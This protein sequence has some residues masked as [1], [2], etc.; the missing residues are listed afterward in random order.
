MK[1]VL[2]VFFSLFILSIKMF[3]GGGP[4][5][6]GYTW[7]DINDVGG[8]TF[9]WFD[10]S[11]I[12]SPLSGLGDDN[13]VGPKP[14]GGNFK[15][16]WGT[17]NKIWAGSN[18]YISFGPANIASPFP[19]IPDASPPNNYIAAMMC[20]LNFTG[21]GNQ[22][23]CLYY[24]NPDTFCISYIDVPFW[25]QN[26]QSWSGQNTFQIILNKSDNS[27][28]FNYLVQNGVSFT[29]DLTIGI[30]NISGTIGLQH[31]K[32]VY[33]TAN[34]SVKFYYPGSTSLQVTDAAIQWNHAFGTGGVFL[35]NQGAPYV[36]KTD[37][38][39]LGNIQIP[40]FNVDGNVFDPNGSQIVSN[41]LPTDTLYQGQDT[42]MTFPNTFSPA[43]PGTYRF[44]GIVSGVSG[45]I[46]AGNDTINQEIVVVDTTQT[47][48]RLSYYRGTPFGGLSWVGGQGGA[49]VYFKP[50]SYPVKVVSTDFYILSSSNA[51]F[52]AKI[53]KD[54]GPNNSPGTLLDSVF[55]PY[56][57]INFSGVTTVPCSAPF[58]ISSGGVYVKWD[59]SGTITLGTDMNGPFSRQTYE[60][61]NNIWSDFRYRETEDLAI[62][63]TYQSYIVEDVGAPHIISPLANATISSPVQ[64]KCWVK[65]Y[66]QA[67]DNS[68]KVK[69]KLA[70]NA[71]IV[72]EN[73]LGP[74]INPGDSAQFTFAT[75]LTPPYTAA[76][77]LC[78]WTYK[79]T[80]LN[81][82]NDSSCIPLNLVG[83]GEYENQAGVHVY[84]VPVR[85]NV[86]FFFDNFLSD[87]VSIQVF[88][89]IGNK[90]FATEL[91]NVSARERHTF[92]LGRLV[93]GTYSYQVRSGDK[94][95]SGRIVKM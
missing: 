78:V 20:D 46:S 45:D 28:T 4:D 61:L 12:G 60:V 75:L 13:Y 91:E 77:L 42:V 51:G 22:G 9:Q 32:N 57:S 84:P 35:S 93:P 55:V 52:W 83:I 5:T 87:H 63:L 56:T 94:R 33:P 53:Y 41:S 8:P 17:Y 19:F 14:I 3:A 30:E 71:N 88:D 68:F 47:N 76:D 70:N 10:I 11:Q 80:D 50:P 85:D 26:V 16:Y 7:K 18:G 65:N 59:M 6:Y 49:G 25:D 43:Q 21:T 58:V 95:S 54:N 23:K 89:V 81:A 1:K 79:S 34:Y 90:V 39:N 86:T 62:G 48:M 72:T 15:F 40:P 27:I 69:Y 37:A 24:A 82:A 74:L 36:L 64:V 66:G 44:K 2:L 29:Q 31:S 67:P 38:W 73:F 92:D